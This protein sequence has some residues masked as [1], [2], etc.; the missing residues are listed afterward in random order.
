MPHP[1]KISSP[2]LLLNDHGK[3]IFSI[4]EREHISKA[5]KGR[6]SLVQTKYTKKCLI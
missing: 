3:I 6:C 2:P 1:Q 4:G 5:P